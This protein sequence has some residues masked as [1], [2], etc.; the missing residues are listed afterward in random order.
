ME[1]IPLSKE[2]LSLGLSLRF[3]LRDETGAIL[4]AKGNKI[5]TAQ[6]LAGIK[7]RKALF[8]EMEES[9]DAVRILMSGLV[10]LNRADAPIKDFAK[11][12]NVNKQ[13]EEDKL[14]GTLVQRWGDLESKLGGLLGSVKTSTVFDQKI[15]ILE[16]HIHK[17]MTEDASSAQFLLFNRA[18]THFSGYSVLHS[19]LCASLCHSLA[20][21]FALPD[22]E[23]ICL[24]CAALTM[25]SAMTALQDELAIQK[26]PP[27][28]GQRST[29]DAHAQAGRQLL[30]EAGVTD[31]LWLEVVA[32]H[33]TPLEG[34]DNLADWTVI[35]R[36][37]KILQTVD[38]YAAAMSPR[39]SRAGR[40]ARDSVKSV[41][42]QAGT[43]KHDEVGSALVRILGLSPPGTYVKLGNGE[44]AVVMRRGAKPAEPIVASVLN[45]NDEPIAEPRLRDVAREQIPIQATLSATS[46]RVN[47]Q[48]EVMMRIMPKGT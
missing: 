36:L 29:I 5:E 27:S 28:V 9:E 31:L 32:L 15:R 18:V 25:N 42:L 12:L 35:K 47:L 19:L 34:P 1:L 26:I 30:I 41:V 20:G 11:F 13:A 3:T 37:S 6:Q 46:I 7:S 39:K 40:T 10:E 24:V 16:R 4:L 48:M 17:L 33:H 2:K 8:I 14:T 38:R 45:R 43:T 22:E 21:V 23:R 44:T